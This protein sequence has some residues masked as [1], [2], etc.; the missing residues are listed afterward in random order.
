MWERTIPECPWLN[1]P[2]VRC[3]LILGHGWTVQRHP[4]KDNLCCATRWRV[5]GLQGEARVKSSRPCLPSPLLGAWGKDVSSLPVPPPN[6]D[7][8]DQG[9]DSRQLWPNFRPIFNTIGRFFCRTQNVWRI[10]YVRPGQCWQ[11]TLWFWWL[12]QLI[13]LTRHHI[14]TKEA[15]FRRSLKND[16]SKNCR[17]LSVLIYNFEL[18]VWGTLLLSN[19]T[20]LL[21]F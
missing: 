18:G 14:L 12:L 5:G 10:F 15:S 19:R 9:A 13:W 1:W 21:R 8:V 11:A 7:P 16:F 20:S 3:P 2:I 17:P 6:A 4:G